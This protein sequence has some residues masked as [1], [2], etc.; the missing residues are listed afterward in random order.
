LAEALDIVVEM[1]PDEKEVVIRMDKLNE[2][3]KEEKDANKN[4]KELDLDLTKS[5]E[6]EKK[7]A[8]GENI[9][10]NKNRKSNLDNI[11]VPITEP[12]SKKTNFFFC[13]F[14]FVISRF[15]CLNFK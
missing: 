4:K 13:P 15:D 6:E 3:A 10:V 14:K 8:K 1:N 5:N 9:T 12:L 2:W 7:E 11:Y